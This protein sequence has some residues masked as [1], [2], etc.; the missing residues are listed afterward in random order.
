MIGGTGNDTYVVDDAGD[1]VMET[2]TIFDEIDTVRAS[3]SHTLSVNVEN[4]IL[5]G[6]ATINGIGNALGNKITGNAADNMLDGGKGMTRWM[7]ARART[8]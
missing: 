7:A 8:P 2:S 4:L 6:S 5:T 3:A 1:V